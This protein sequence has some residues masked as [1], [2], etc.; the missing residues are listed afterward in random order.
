MSNKLPITDAKTSRS[1]FSSWV[2]RRSDKRG[3]TLFTSIRTGRFTTLPH[4]KGRD[5]NR[6]LIR[7]ILRE[8]QLTPEEYRGQLK[9]K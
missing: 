8:I 7:Q 2:L 6:P 3:V 9:K 5:L 1:S 4:H